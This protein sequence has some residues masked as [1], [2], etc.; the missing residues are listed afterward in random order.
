MLAAFLIGILIGSLLSV[1]EKL[2][3][4]NSVAVFFQRTSNEKIL[5]K[6]IKFFF[7]K[8]QMTVES[9]K[10]SDRDSG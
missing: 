1:D 9:P 8:K 6:S 3:C 7:Q 10:N 4:K 2:L 5:L